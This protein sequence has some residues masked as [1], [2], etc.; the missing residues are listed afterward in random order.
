MKISF[1]K[2]YRHL[3]CLPTDLASDI[4]KD[5]MHWLA[6]ETLQNLE[7][8]SKSD[9]WSFASTVWEIFT[10]GQRPFSEFI[11]WNGN[12]IYNCRVS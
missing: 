5:G 8:S 4:L 2:G 7:F 3:E 10:R 9:I 6:P 1:V 11:C 12:Q